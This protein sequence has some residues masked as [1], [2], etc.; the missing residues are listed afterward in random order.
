MLMVQSLYGPM[1]KGKRG[2]AHQGRGEQKKGYQ[3]SW[4]TFGGPMSWQR[5]P[6]DYRKRR[7]EVEIVTTL[8]WPNVLWPNR[9]MST[10]KLVIKKKGEQKRR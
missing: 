10:F 4:P 8:T 6:A 7:T 1:L 5:V 9:F 3:C 2:S